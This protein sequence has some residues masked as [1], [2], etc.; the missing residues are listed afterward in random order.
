WQDI[1]TSDS[2]GSGNEDVLRYQDAR[3]LAENDVWS[4]VLGDPATGAPPL[5]PLMHESVA[6]RQGATPNLAPLAPPESAPFANPVNGH[7]Y[8]ARADLQYACIFPLQMPLP[9]GDDQSC[10]CE[11]STSTLT[12]LCQQPDGSYADTQLYAKAYPGLRHLEVLQG[13]GESGIVASICPKVSPTAGDAATPDPN[14]GYN[15]A[16]DALLTVIGS[17][18]GG[19]CVP[20]QL[21]PDT[22]TGRVP[23]AMVEVLPANAQGQCEPCSAVPGRRD[24]EAKLARSVRRELQA[25]GRCTTADCPGTCL[26]EIEQSEGTELD[27]CQTESNASS[28][29]YCYIDAALSLGDPALV[30]DCPGQ[31]GLRFVGA[32]TPRNGAQTFIACVGASFADAP[33][34]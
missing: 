32:D 15:P 21:A 26:C 1:A 27:A 3:T 2:L 4:L 17:K 5:D 6:P 24:P 14:V 9:C 18:L 25:G 11:D 16:V 13:V 31:R 7:E 10:D 30:Q 29:G 12:P 22:T 20:R 19:K 28:P 8:Y 33:A 34:P 23:C